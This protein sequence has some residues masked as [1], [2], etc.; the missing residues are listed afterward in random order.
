MLHRGSGSL[1]FVRSDSGKYF[2]GLLKQF[3]SSSLLFVLF[4]AVM[5][6][7]G[8]GT[9]TGTVVDPGAALV[10]NAK[11]VITNEA[12]HVSVNAVTGDA[13]VFTVPELPNGIYDVHVTA[14]GF[15]EFIQTGITVSVGNTASVNVGL[16]LGGTSEVV[17]IH[18]DVAQIQSETSDIGTSVDSRLNLDLPLP[19]SNQVRSPLNFVTLT[20]GFSGVVGNDPTTH[21]QFK[22]NGGQQDGADVLIDGVSIEYASPNVQQNYGVSMEAV[23]EFKV[24]TGTFSAEY[25]RTSGG[26]VDLVVKSG[27]NQLHGTAYEILRNTVL[28]SA[29]WIN[30]YRGGGRPIDRQNDFGG[31]LSGP[32]R[33]PKLY[34]GKDKTFFMFNYEGYRY[35]NSSATYNTLPLPAYQQGDFSALLH[36]ETR[37]GQTFVPHQLYNPNTGLPYAG[38]IIPMSQA[39]PVTQ[40]MMKYL[41]AGPD[42]RRHQ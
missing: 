3:I 6:A 9:I 16:Q 30:N 23:S 18:G 15:K 4:S 22:V 34:N 36:S 13:G 41:P 42:Q 11:V 10:P 27:T 12:T 14:S 25:G 17:E 33:I 21:S 29:G 20:P 2:V 39:D 1:E 40:K 19:L 31:Q 5:W 38:N 7:Q 37:L 24:L 28:D 26:L 35:S 32:I 8:T